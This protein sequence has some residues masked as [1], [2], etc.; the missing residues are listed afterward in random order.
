[1]LA[2]FLLALTPLASRAQEMG[3]PFL[4]YYAPSEYN[5]GSVMYQAA[6]D[7]RGFILFAN[8]WNVRLY[9]G[10]SWSY[11]QMANQREA[12][13]FALANDGTV[14]VGGSDEVGFLA[15]NPLGKLEFV[16]LMPQFPASAQA[17]GAVRQAVALPQGVVFQAAKT[18][19]FWNG[20]EGKAFHL[21]T[22]ISFFGKL[23][24]QALL[25]PQGGRPF[26][27][28]PEGTAPF[29]G[30]SSLDGLRIVGLLAQPGQAHPAL[31]THEQGVMAYDSGQQAYRPIQGNLQ[32]FLRRHPARCALRLHQGHWAIGT[33][34][35]G[36][37]VADSLG[38]LLCLVDPASGLRSEQVNHIFED[39][40]HILWLSLG[41]GAAK[42]EINTPVTWW[43]EDAGLK[44]NVHTLQ[45][46]QGKLHAGTSLGLF[47]LEEGMEG[48]AKFVP[49]PELAAPVYSSQCQ[50]LDGQ[51]Y[52][53]AATGRGPAVVA[54]SPNGGYAVKFLQEDAPIRYLTPSETVPNRIY[55][56]G[57]QGLFLI[58]PENGKWQLK[59]PVA[60]LE[61]HRIGLIEEDTLGQIWAV[62]VAEGLL[63]FRVGPD[64]RAEGLQALKKEQGLPDYNFLGVDKINRE[65]LLTSERGVYAFQPQEGRFRIASHLGKQLADF[66]T[67]FYFFEEDDQGK[68]W[69][70]AYRDG[71]RL[72]REYAVRQPDGTYAVDSTTLRR[73]PVMDGTREGNFAEPGGVVWFGGGDGLFRYDSGGEMVATQQFKAYFRRIT[74][75]EQGPAI[76]DDGHAVPNASGWR[77]ADRQA[78]GA[79]REIPYDSN[80]LVVHFAS[81]SF[82]EEEQN[83]YSF[84]LE[85]SGEGWSTWSRASSEHFRNLSEGTYTLQVR[86]RNIYGAVSEP[87][88]YTFVVRPPWYRSVAA[89]VG[90]ALLAWLALYLNTLRMRRQNVRLERLVKERTARIEKQKEEIEAQ[91]DHLKQANE[92]IMA[93]N[94]ALAQQQEELVAKSEE[95][96][97]QNEALES[98]NKHITDSINYAGRI[99]KALL[100]DERDILSRF[101]QAFVFLKPRDI[102]S[103]DFYWFS[104]CFGADGQE[105]CSLLIAADCTGHGVPGAFMTVMGNAL[106]HEIVNER[107]VWEPSQI[108]A[109][110][111]QRVVSATSRQGGQVN[112]GMDMAVVRISPC[113]RYITFA[114]AKNPLYRVRNGEVDTFKGSKFPIGS[115][116]FEQKLFEH[117]EV[118]VQPGDQFYLASDGFQDQFGGGDGRKYLRKRF[119]ELL[120]AASRL[121][122]PEQRAFFDQELAAWKGH[123]SQT[124]DILIIGFEAI[125]HDAEAC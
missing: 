15:P 112:D 87:D 24:G 81:N 37:A 7:E 102:V 5:A 105:A 53:L 23:G 117:E 11:I 6:Q 119:R 2:G 33:S 110:L 75:G 51:P 111:D 28:S 27:W 94:D 124:D 50:T 73:I 93:K 85:G 66:Y 68:L 72:W 104:Q 32:G 45:R 88:T 22:A 89:Y 123:C 70:I 3:R 86:A 92:E 78:Q 20:Q 25:Q 38:N 10:V 98:K 9:D 13:S 35:G 60:G 26:L 67:G 12:R 69:Y 121:P 63:R 39:K 52:L 57:H 46:F 107:K 77:R 56:L 82:F 21:D 47:R 58:E 114:G 31:V 29:P 109:Q 30:A 71:D 55:A 120:Q 100:G 99:Q 1:M 14:Y 61:G 17:V 41:N 122:M 74:L 42:A 90:Y 76:F 125:P 40:D 79:W 84:L 64:L 36:M 4:R 83:E 101:P 19:L 65:L 48:H 62:T 8:N 91:A 44:G 18:L 113:R 95:I 16:S 115:S 49:V 96:G 103:G 43:N 54:Y 59:G 80:S 118:D 34:T 108:L 97:R 106:L 116:Q